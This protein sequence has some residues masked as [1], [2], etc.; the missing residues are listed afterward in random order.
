LAFGWLGFA[1]CTTPPPSS[2]DVA[3]AIRASA[4][5]QE[6]RWI[7]LKARER[8]SCSEAL[9]V[10]REWSEWKALGLLDAVETVTGEG[11]V[12]Q[13]VLSEES[14]REDQNLSHQ[15]TSRG[16]AAGDSLDELRVPVAGRNFVRTVGIRQSSKETAE[17]DFEWQW[18]PNR[19]GEK[20]IH[21]NVINSAWAQIVS[22]E[23]GW[24]VVSVRFSR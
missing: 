12:C 19:I 24:H 9:A 1:G 14:R 6:A 8:G 17:V 22:D 23:R 20:L 10:N 16:S 3:K 18:R 7:A 5:F 11:M 2:Q 15:L 13:A 4:P 21:D